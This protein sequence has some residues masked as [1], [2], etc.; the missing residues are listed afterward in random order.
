MKNIFIKGITQNKNAAFL[1]VTY[2]V[3]VRGNP[4]NLTYK[5]SGENIDSVPMLCDAVIVN[6]LY[7]AINV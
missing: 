5:I 4:Y 3:V 6:L 1:E 7:Y 2:T